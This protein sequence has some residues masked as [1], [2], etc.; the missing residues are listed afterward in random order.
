M[1][2]PTAPFPKRF[3]RDSLQFDCKFPGSVSPCGEA[4]IFHRSITS[5]C[6]VSAVLMPSIAFIYYI[7]DQKM[8]QDLR[9]QKISG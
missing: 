4:G 5:L 3:M 8:I 6:A 9:M 2:L 7:S 1:K